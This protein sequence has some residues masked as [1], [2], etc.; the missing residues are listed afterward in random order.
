MACAN[1]QSIYR[2]FENKATLTV[3]LVIAAASSLSTDSRS[4]PVVPSALSPQN[5]ISRFRSGSGPAATRVRAAAVRGVSRSGL[6]RGAAAAG[7]RRAAW[8]ASASSR[9]CATC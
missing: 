1:A 3:P 6:A 5:L 2:L 7:V 4:G 8:D 9:P